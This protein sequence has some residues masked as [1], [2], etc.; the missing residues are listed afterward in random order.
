MSFEE[1]VRKQIAQKR[2]EQAAQKAQEE[3]LEAERIRKK[4]EQAN[5][6]AFTFYDKCIEIAAGGMHSLTMYVV[7]VQEMY[8]GSVIGL[9]TEKQEKKAIE[10]S[11]GEYFDDSSFGGY[12]SMVRFA[13]ALPKTFALNAANEIENEL[14]KKGLANVYTK[15]HPVYKWITHPPSFF[16]HLG[17]IEKTKEV[18]GYYVQITASW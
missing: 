15:L 18:A 6:C 9:I 3:Q 16:H 5:A 17:R 1:D 7:E 10:S 14:H 4:A 12:E 2:D 13:K 8:R 11:V